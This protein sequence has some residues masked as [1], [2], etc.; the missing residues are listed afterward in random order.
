M[1]LVIGIEQLGDTIHVAARKIKSGN[2]TTKTEKVANCLAMAV[3]KDLERQVGAGLLE[4][5]KLSVDNEPVVT[6]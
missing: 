3:R 1:S 6:I 5:V 2:V 4:E